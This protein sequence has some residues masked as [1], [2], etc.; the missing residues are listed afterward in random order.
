MAGR[1]TCPPNPHPR[2]LSTSWRGRALR[3][4]TPPH[5]RALLSPR[6]GTEGEVSKGRPLRYTP[7]QKTVPEAPCPRD[8]RLAVPL[9]APARPPRPGPTPRRAHE[10]REAGGEA[11][12]SPARR[13]VFGHPPLAD[14][15]RQGLPLHRH[16]RHPAAQ[17]RRGHRQG[18]RLLHRLH[19]RRR[20]GPGRAGRSPS[21]STAA[22]ARRRSG[23]TSAPSARSG[24]RGPTRG[25]P[26]RRRAGW[27][28]TKIRILDATDLVF[29]DPVST[30]FS[31]P[32]PGQDREAVPRRQG[33][34]RLGRRLHPPLGHPQPALGLPQV[35]RRRELRH[36]PRGRPRLPARGPLRHDAQRRRPDLLRPQ[37]AG[38]G[39]PPRQRPP[40]LHPP[41]DLRRHRLVPQEAAAG[42]LGRPAQDPVGG[43]GLRPRRV[44]A[45]PAPGGPPARRPAQ[46]DRGQGRPL[47]RPL[48]EPTSSARTSA[49]RSTASSRSCCATRGRPSAAST[50]ASPAATSTRRARSHEFDPGQRLLDGPYAAAINDYIR[51][52][53]KFENDLVYERLTDKVWPWDWDLPQPVRRTWPSPCARR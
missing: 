34:H 22:P 2:S 24:W 6:R 45:G 18:V 26:C 21:A 33:G 11:A 41:A 42:A 4:G 3:S 37:L 35:R 39:L 51:R 43:R 49:S 27:S 5:Q 13:E 28:T 47:H 38:P 17:E 15:G 50:P 25:S 23:C 44:R 29:I 14:P 48:A 30:G 52:D 7:G 36:H 20:E 16:R 31:R 40:L 10:G 12:A 32:A 19:A 8:S 1:A 9:A 46:G 53:L